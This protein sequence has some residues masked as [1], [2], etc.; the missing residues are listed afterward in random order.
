MRVFRRYPGHT[1]G[2]VRTRRGPKML[3]VL[4]HVVAGYSGMVKGGVIF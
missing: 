1:N 3:G 4:L 2:E